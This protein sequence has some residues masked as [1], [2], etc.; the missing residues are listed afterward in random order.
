MGWIFTL[1]FEFKKKFAAIFNYNYQRSPTW[2]ISVINVWYCAMNLS[3]DCP[4]DAWHCV[5]GSLTLEGNWRCFIC[6]S[7]TR[8]WR[9][10][11]QK[12]RV[13]IRRGNATRR[14]WRRRS[15]AESAHSTWR[16]CPCSTTPSN[17]VQNSRL[18]LLP[19]SCSRDLG[20]F[21]VYENV[22]TLCNL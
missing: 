16:P 6:C 18:L 7:W 17:K 21:F 9:L 4:Q 19:Q 11:A 10:R 13:C 2:D 5:K 15:C 12:W 20:F 22:K 3:T 14:R 8:L 1:T